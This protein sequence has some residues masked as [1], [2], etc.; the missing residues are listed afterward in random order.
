MKHIK[1]LIPITLCVFTAGSLTSFTS[2]DHLTKRQEI[3]AI[4]EMYVND[5]PVGVMKHAAKGLNYYDKVMDTLKE[6][7]PEDVDILSDVYF[8]EVDAMTAVVTG[9]P[10]IAAAIEKA[11][12]IETEAYAIKIN[13][14]ILCHVRS[15]EE[16]DRIAKAIQEPYVQQVKSTG[17]SQLEEVKFAEDVRFDQEKIAFDMLADENEAVDLLRQSKA[18][19]MK[20]TI[21][22]GDSLWTIASANKIHVNDILALNPGLDAEHI[23]PGDTIAL[24]AEKALVSVITKEKISYQEE[25]PFTTENKEDNT[26]LK[27]KTK[28]VQEGKNGKKELQAY[29]TRENGREVGREVVGE[30]VVEKPVNKII[31]KGTKKKPA[32]VSA[33]IKT[34]SASVASNPVQV[35]DRGSARGSEVVSFARQY[36][37]KPYSYGAGGPNSFDCSGFTSF[38]YRHFGYSIPRSSGSQGGA[39]RAVSKANLAAGDIVLFTSPNSGG[40]IGHVGIYIGGGNFIHASSGSEYCVTISN[41]NSGSYARRYKGARR[42]L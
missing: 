27:G 22:E 12:D 15:K 11:V 20:Y 4:Y 3:A 2:A 35:A 33:P 1:I 10:K 30:T 26:I 37:G 36:L 8:K 7:Y 28:T 16:A 40:A 23:K 42:I 34:A 18:N 39:G 19:E 5:E 13:G 38:V 14:N 32:A 21:A 9:E 24:S 31:A 17:T 25:I 29:V 6:E 41:L